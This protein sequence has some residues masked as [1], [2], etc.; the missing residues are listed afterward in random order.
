MKVC[1]RMANRKAKALFGKKDQFILESLRT[2]SSMEKVT[3][4]TKREVNTKGIGCTE[5]KKGKENK[6]SLMI[7]FMKENSRT[8]EGKAT[9][10]ALTPKINFIPALKANG[11]KVSL[12]RANLFLRMEQFLMENGVTISFQV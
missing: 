12:S 11:K 4:S 1:L 6:K 3:K 7:Q 10:N 5:R 8:T 2:V 9:E